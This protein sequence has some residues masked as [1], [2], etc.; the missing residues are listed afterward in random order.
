M[1]VGTRSAIV[2]TFITT[3]IIPVVDSAHHLVGHAWRAAGSKPVS[4]FKG[5]Q[6]TVDGKTYACDS[7]IV[8]TVHLPVKV[9][10]CPKNLWWRSG[11]C[12][13]KS[14]ARATATR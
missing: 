3:L 9:K 13:T 7:R 14:A 10:L 11:H 4:C 2:A 12:V 6:V 5:D 1:S 8:N